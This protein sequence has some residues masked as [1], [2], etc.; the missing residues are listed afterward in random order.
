MKIC[1][2]TLFC[3]INIFAIAFFS[4]SGLCQT[5]T[6]PIGIPA[7]EFG[8]EETVE[9]IYGAGYYTHYIDNT[10]PNAT[11]TDNPYGTADKPRMTIPKRMMNL[12]A[13]SVV[14]IHGGPYS[15]STPARWTPNGT[16]EQPVF[17]RGADPNNRVI[18][19][20][21]E[22]QIGGKYFILENLELYYKSHISLT[23][24]S[25]SHVAVRNCEIHNPVGTLSGF[26]SAIY[27]KGEHIVI[28]KNHIHHNWKGDNE[29]C[30]GVVPGA[31]A[32]RVWVLDNHIHHNS[33]DSFQATHGASD[34]P[35]QYVYVG[36]NLM[37]ED[38]ENAVDLKYVKDIVISQNV[39]YGYKDASTSDGSVMILGSD[40]APNRPWVLF[41]EIRDSRNGIRTEATDKAWIIGNLIY[42]IQGFAFGLE[43]RAD[44]LYII[45]NTVNNVGLS[46]DQ[47]WRETFR[48]HIFNNIFA[49][50]KKSTVHLNIESQQ[51]ADASEMSHNLFWQ[52]GDPV[53][54]RWAY[55]NKKNYTSTADFDG[56]AGG[57]NNIIGDPYFKDAVN[58][59]FSLTANS[60]AIDAGVLQAA[61][62]RFYDI[63]GIN[64]KVD[65]S[66]KA[67]PLGENWDVGA[68]E[69]GE[70]TS[71]RHA[72]ETTPSDY[73]LQN[74]PNPF[75]PTTTIRFQIPEPS[76]VKL[77]IFTITGQK[78]VT[79][80]NHHYDM[81][82]HTVEWN[83][84]DINNQ[85][86]VSGVFFY[87][88]TTES[89]IFTKK[90]LLIR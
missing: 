73:R 16:K 26:G 78:V 19:K 37:H 4:A 36:R 14:E 15:F 3:F 21:S 46:I 83:G 40:G 65:F 23:Y 85:Q 69:Y 34:N 60:A 38:R 1:Q 7:P 44:D 29:D 9:N 55:G 57:A 56:F 74:Y 49:N 13:G 6:P 35:P 86:V 90:M 71:V 48:L 68:F 20:R 42:N 8:I 2:F 81:G 45:G 11:D 39:C 30:H 50:I 43:K 10:H 27:A 61:Y 31:G 72:R 33:G 22:L 58:H 54:V 18:I 51:V 84:R 17:I 24:S 28:Y 75:N 87:R 5:Y 77:E 41:N 80:V 63:Y 47:F 67:R 59:D 79:L 76:N 52:G 62:D 89:R 32:R 66:G 12:P 88:L 53:I 70:A 64:I 25:P 82:T